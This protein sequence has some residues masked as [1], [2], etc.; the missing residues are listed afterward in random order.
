MASTT[1]VVSND[2]ITAAESTGSRLGSLTTVGKVRFGFFT[3]AALLLLALN[4][5]LVPSTALTR[6]VLGFVQEFGPHQIHDMVGSAIVWLAF[7]APLAL[8][9]YHP[10]ER[11]NTVLVPIMVTGPIA[12]LGY[13]SDSPLVMAY[14]IVSILALVVVGFHPAGRSLVQFDRVESVDRRLAGLF[15]VGAVPLLIYAALEVS[16][17]LGPVDEH[18]LFVHYGAMAIAAFLVVFM[19]AMAVFRQRDRRFATWFAGLMAAY[20]G[21]A[22]IAYPTNASS[23]GLVGGALLFLWAVAFV[24]GVEYV[25]RSDV[26]G[27]ADSSDDFVARSA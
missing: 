4:V 17:Q 3:L 13:L 8:L 21:L 5:L 25:R 27:E 19:G 7:V 15:A 10:K 2:R 14:S 20:I 1:P 6:V 12:V 18:G 9:L 23:V 16:K 22:S 26:D 11:V 24:A